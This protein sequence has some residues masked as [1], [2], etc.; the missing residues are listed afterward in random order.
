LIASLGLDTDDVSLDFAVHGTA[1]KLL[2]D[3]LGG[4][5]CFTETLHDR[6]ALLL[7]RYVLIH[8]E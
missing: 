4:F 1:S 5:G 8:P 6:S 3:R 7:W 2:R